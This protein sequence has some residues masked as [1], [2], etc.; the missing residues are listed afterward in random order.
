[1]PT[2]GAFAHFPGVSGIPA[3]QYLT[4][5]HV[6]WP[7][8]GSGSADLLCFLEPSGGSGS[9]LGGQGFASTLGGGSAPLNGHLTV[10]SGTVS[11]GVQC[12][13]VSGTVP[14]F[15]NDEVHVI[16]VTLH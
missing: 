10:S 5:G 3:G 12:Q 7:K 6:T 1:V 14:V 9:S 4:S 15:V 2:G 8:L 13:E 16:R 11:V